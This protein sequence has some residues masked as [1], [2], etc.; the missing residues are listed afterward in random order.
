MGACSGDPEPPSDPDPDLP[1]SPKANVRAKNGRQLQREFART[2]ELPA[3]Q[4]C[5]ELGQYNCFDIHAV[6]LGN[7]DAFGSG[8][9]E[10]LPSSTNTSP[11]AVE[12]IALAGCSQR[13]ALDG[14]APGSAVIYQDVEVDGQGAL[15][16]VESPAVVASLDRLYQRALSRRARESEI[17]HLQQLYRD[18]E[19][20]GVSGAPAGDWAT[21]ACFAVLTSMESLFY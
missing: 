14:D 13:V 19:A 18:I 8:L 12:R 10:A 3:G 2:L 16:D 11:I 15:V 1:V 17:A 7:T 9:Y 4:I 6:V 5:R 21:L 20:A